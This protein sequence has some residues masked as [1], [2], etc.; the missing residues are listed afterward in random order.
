MPTYWPKGFLYICFLL[1]LQ[2]YSKGSSSDKEVKFQL[3]KVTLEPMLK[4]MASISEQLAPPG[5]QVAVMNLKVCLHF[6]GALFTLMQ[7]STSFQVFWVPKL[8]FCFKIAYYA[9]CIFQILG[10]HIWLPSYSG[11]SLTEGCIVLEAGLLSHWHWSI[12]KLGIRPVDNY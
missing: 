1:Q 12:Q 9:E 2:D 11:W 3:S 6:F 10:C 4:S 7:L 8:R 5:N